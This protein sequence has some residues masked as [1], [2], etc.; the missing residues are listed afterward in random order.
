MVTRD[1]PPK[2]GGI[3]SHA[4][5]LVDSLSKFGVEVKIFEGGGDISTLLLPREA[6]VNSPSFDLL[7]VQSTPYGAFAK[8]HPLVLTAHSPVLEER[9]FYRGLNS[10]K[11]PFAYRLERR[12]LKKADRVI[13]VSRATHELL[14]EGY[15]V[16]REKLSLIP[17][18]VDCGK[19]KPGVR[20]DPSP[21][22]I[23]ICSR[24]DPRKNISVG[25]EAL[26]EVGRK[27][28]VRIIGDGPEKP[29]LEALGKKLTN[30][31]HFLGRVEEAKLVDEFSTSDIFLSTSLSEGFGLSL[32][33]AMASGCA[34]I[35]S[36]I[37]AHRELVEHMKDGL[38]Y[39]TK[40]ELGENL[41]LLM[42][43]LVLMKRLGDA[44]RRKALTFGWDR[45]AE[46]TARLYSELLG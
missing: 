26:S 44:A 10:W 13:A 25:L 28:E 39:S 14:A 43:D 33:Q 41:E 21:P 45:V 3:P 17:N 9:K 15:G 11:A 36:D 40:K 38:V 31:A 7:H 6:E 8:K 29:R 18:G 16:P 37:A 5:A 27:Y 42:T 24:L 23:L 2:V 35:A 22:K 46:A 19:F 30:R 4:K 34:V 12:S 20:S 32:L 1:Y